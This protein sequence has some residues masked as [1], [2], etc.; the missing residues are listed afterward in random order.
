[1]KPIGPLAIALKRFGTGRAGLV[2]AAALIVL[3]VVGLLI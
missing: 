1:M 2:L 3:L